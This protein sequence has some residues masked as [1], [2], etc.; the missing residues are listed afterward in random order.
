MKMFNHEFNLEDAIAVRVEEKERETEERML[1]VFAR[2]REAYI[3]QIRSL[4]GNPLV[5]P[6]MPSAR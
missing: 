4:G 1:A 3:Q 5:Q 6:I 2:E